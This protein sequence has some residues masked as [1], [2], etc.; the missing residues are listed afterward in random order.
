[1]KTCISYASDKYPLYHIIVYADT[2]ERELNILWI[3]EKKSHHY[4]LTHIIIFGRNDFLSIPT[5]ADDSR[6]DRIS[7]VREK[8]I[9]NVNIRIQILN[10]NYSFDLSEQ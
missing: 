2:N 10:K 4:Y 8:Y 1:M 5:L 3:Y 7:K 6:F 9:D